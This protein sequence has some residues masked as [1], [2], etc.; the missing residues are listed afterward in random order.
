MRRIN[1]YLRAVF[2]LLVLG[3]LGSWLVVQRLI[4]YIQGWKNKEKH[5]Q[6]TAPS[7]G[8]HGVSPVPAFTTELVEGI[9]PP[10]PSFDAE[11]AN[12][13]SEAEIV[14]ETVEA[15]CVK[16]RQKRALQEAKPVITKK[17]RHAMEGMCPVC[18]T[19]LFRFIARKTDMLLEQQ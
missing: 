2:Q 8:E 3:I 16:C 10:A 13:H 7:I 19:K 14:L 1:Y 17:G 9:L 12:K 18:G 4:R 15:Y 5:E 11:S 6:V